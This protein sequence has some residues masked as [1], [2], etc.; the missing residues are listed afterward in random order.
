M[1]EYGLDV[2]G[3]QIVHWL[4]SELAA[5][6]RSLDI[7]A[8]CEYVTAPVADMEAF[9]LSDEADVASLVTVGLLEVRPTGESDGWLLRVRVED[10]VGPHTPED[11]SVPDIPEEID[12]EDF[13]SDFIVPDRGTIYVT[14][15]AE[16]PEAKRRFDRLFADLIRDRH[17]K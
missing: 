7:R 17:R 8:T 16:T 5:G 2:T 9:G 10:V 6:R 3:D 13:S 15:S 12:L 1:T 4:K 11:E 14:V